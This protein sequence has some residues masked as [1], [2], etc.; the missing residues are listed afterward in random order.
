MQVF[1][2]V[3]PLFP[4]SQTVRWNETSC[5]RMNHQPDNCAQ[6]RQNPSVSACSWQVMFG[7]WYMK[8]SATAVQSV[9]IV[10]VKPCAGTN[11]VILGTSPV[12]NGQYRVLQCILSSVR[13]GT[14]VRDCWSFER[15]RQQL[16]TCSTDGPRIFKVWSNKNKRNAFFKVDHIFN[17][18]TRSNMFRRL[19]CAIFKEPKEILPK[20]CVCYVIS[21]ICEGREWIPSGAVSR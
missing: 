7:S 17:I 11:S 18:S 2:D 5:C 16:C 14:E 4:S 20:L 19:R 21:R 10:I 8:A 15:L 3:G 13:Y 1:P 6:L 12:M 9:S